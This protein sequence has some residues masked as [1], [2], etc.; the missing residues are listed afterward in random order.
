M[1]ISLVVCGFVVVIAVGYCVWFVLF[2]GLLRFIYCAW[3][4]CCLGY[5][6]LWLVWFTCKACRFAV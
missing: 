1:F 6:C 2:S 5:G 3:G 4:A